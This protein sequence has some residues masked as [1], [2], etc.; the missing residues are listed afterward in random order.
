MIRHGTVVEL[1]TEL[2]ATDELEDLESEE[3]R[4][5]LPWFFGPRLA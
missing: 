1:V 2:N 4:R 3:A 5:D